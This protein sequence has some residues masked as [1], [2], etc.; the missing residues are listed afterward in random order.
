VLADLLLETPSDLLHGRRRLAPGRSR[1]VG[2]VED[3]GELVAPDPAD[4]VGRADRALEG[5]D[6]LDEDLVARG[7]A[8]EVVVRLELVDVE[9][10]DGDGAAGV[11]GP[12]EGGV[13]E[14]LE[15]AAVPGAGERVG[16]GGAAE[17]ALAVVVVEPAGEPVGVGGERG[18]V[19]ARDEQAETL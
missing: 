11:A 4:S 9:D 17:G 1:P 18:A 8:V 6:G 7:V 15:V 10:E 3:H 12:G 19:A 13:E 5:A 2:L 14:A 16:E